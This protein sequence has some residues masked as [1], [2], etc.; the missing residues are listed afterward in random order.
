MSTIKGQSSLRE[1]LEPLFSG[2]SR[3]PYYILIDGNKEPLNTPA[4]ALYEMVAH[5]GVYELVFIT[6]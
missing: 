4:P 6:A 5:N 2:K 1:G 3:R